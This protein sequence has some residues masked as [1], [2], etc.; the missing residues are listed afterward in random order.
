[1]RDRVQRTNSLPTFKRNPNSAQANTIMSEPKSDSTPFQAKRNIGGTHGNG[2]PNN[3]L[4]SKPGQSRKRKS[5]AAVD[6]VHDE[7]MEQAKGR[8]RNRY[9]SPLQPVSTRTRYTRLSGGRRVIASMKTTTVGKTDDPKVVKISAPKALQIP[10][11]DAKGDIFKCILDIQ[12]ALE[13]CGDDK[14]PDAQNLNHTVPDETLGLTEAEFGRVLRGIFDYE[15][16]V[17]LRH[18]MDRNCKV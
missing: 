16:H 9:T 14:G 7:M 12:P 4:V 18:E 8:K 5:R 1:M 17:R 3:S 11:K 2:N 6:V 15:L 10:T 13:Y